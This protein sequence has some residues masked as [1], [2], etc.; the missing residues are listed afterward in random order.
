ME[1]ISLVKEKTFSFSMNVILEE[2][3]VQETLDQVSDEVKERLDGQGAQD[4]SEVLDE[5]LEEVARPTM[6]FSQW[7]DDDGTRGVQGRE[8]LYRSRDELPCAWLVYPP[9]C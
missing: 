2:L 7:F 8:W 1:T 3:R 4:N 6:D 9:S 5:G